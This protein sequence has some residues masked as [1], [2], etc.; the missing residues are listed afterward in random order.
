MV[1]HAV[2]LD[3]PTTV[4]DISDPKLLAL[5]VYDMQVRILTQLPTASQT[6]AGELHVVAAARR[7]GCGLS[8]LNEHRR[9]YRG[10]APTP[11]PNP[12]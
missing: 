2:G 1:L 8:S 12:L 6:M 5:L 7:A 4:E 3:I 11:A 10:G 9:T